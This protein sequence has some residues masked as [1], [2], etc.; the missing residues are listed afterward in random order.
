M[1]QRKD[2]LQKFNISLIFSLM[3][4][5]LT[6]PVDTGEGRTSV[7][8]SNEFKN[9]IEIKFLTTNVNSNLKTHGIIFS[10]KGRS[11]QSKVRP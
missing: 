10:S 1:N 2:S 6:S 9:L 11:L 5:G 4:T 3:Q 8:S 7:C